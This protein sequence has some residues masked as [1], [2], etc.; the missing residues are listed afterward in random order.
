MPSFSDFNIEKMHN[1]FN[2]CASLEE[3]TFPWIFNTKKVKDMPNIFSNCESL[4][5]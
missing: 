5:T 2:G 4:K 1:M 3:I